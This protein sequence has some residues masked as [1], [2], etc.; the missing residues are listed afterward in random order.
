MPAAPTISVVVPATDAPA[1]LDRCLAA[2][3]A[4]SGF[5]ELLVV[6]DP[7]HAGPAEAR[8]EG[9]RR[10]TSEVL[11]FVDADVLVHRGAIARIR[12]AFAGDPGLTAIF[13]SYDDSPE[14]P[15]A[16]SGFRNLLHH[17]THQ[18][19]GG[20]AVTFWAGLGAVRRDAF[21]GA[22]GFDSRRYPRPSIEDI[23]L[24]ARLSARGARIVLDPELQGTH[25]KGWT[26]AGVIHTDFVRRGVPWVEL[27]ARPGVSRDVLNL[28]WRNRLSTVAV[29]A[30]A[31]ALGRRRSAPALA[32]AAALAWLNRG[33]YAL[34]ARRR[35]PLEAVA[36]TGLHALHLL[37]AA[38]AVPAGLV[39]ARL[40]NAETAPR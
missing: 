26:L 4:A 14:A 30:L 39:R 8:N 31:L 29:L 12:A 6:T 9:A 32:S 17:H 38:V 37:V 24:G 15:G 2:L 19:A 11:V 27:L 16:V 18:L 35:G 13:G 33:F 21:L 28:G 36:G 23:E 20:R 22:G 10:A 25:L 34:L 1:T 3:R 40:A 7:P 5:E